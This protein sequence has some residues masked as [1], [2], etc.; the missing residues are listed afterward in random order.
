MALSHSPQVVTNGLVYYHDMGNTQKSWKGQPSANLLTYSDDFSNAIWTKNAS[1]ITSDLTIAPDGTTTADKLIENT[2]A[3][4]HYV[5]YNNAPMVSGTRNTI[6]IYAKSNERGHLT[7]YAANKDAGGI[8]VRFN[9]SDG[10]STIIG[11]LANLTV[12]PSINVGNSWWRLSIT[13]DGGTGA[14]VPQ[15]VFQTDTGSSF[16]YAGT[17]NYGVYIWG[18]QLEAATF[19]TPYIPTTTASTSRANT[20]SIID[21]TG[22][23]TVTANSLTYASDNTISFNGTSNYIEISNNNGFGEVSTTPTISL[24]IWTNVSRKSGGG[25]KYQQLA[26]FRNETNFDFYFLLLDASGA[27]VNAEARVRTASGYFDIVVDYLSYFNNWTHIVFIANATR[28]DL[29]LN[30]ISVG[31]NTSIT[32]SFGSTSGNFRVGSSP[33]GGVAL[34]PTQG[35]IGVVKVYNRALTEGE[36][37]QNFNALKGR[38]G[39]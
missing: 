12:N 16:S 33:V 22:N 18:A 24:E 26:G 10:T 28:T 27:S 3:A 23:T 39:L 2:S 7:F 31:S 35:N 25:V 11:N 19:A 4:E 37:Q 21:M 20:Q 17:A 29:Y 36:V 1:T 15:V 13:I 5:L 6:S 30:G 34:W 32:G 8:R 14:T 38:Y 9:L